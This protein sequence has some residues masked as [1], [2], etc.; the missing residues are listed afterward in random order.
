M[1]LLKFLPDWIF[2]AMLVA[3]AI[4]IVASKFAPA[5]YRSA[6]MAASAGVFLIGVFMAGAIHDN[7][8]WLARIKEL[9]LKTAKVEVE[10][11]KETAKVQV[12]V[13]E[14]TQVVKVRGDD[15]I[16]YVDREIVKYD[17]TCKIPK[18]LTEALNKAAEPIK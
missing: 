7:D 2:Y 13:I 12:K 9:E 11:T 4:G 5:Y 6:V 8:A 15:I 14:K 16:K 17:E 10:S 18:E 3:G 1:W